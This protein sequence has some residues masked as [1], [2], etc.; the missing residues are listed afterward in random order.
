MMTEDEMIVKAKRA[1]KMGKLRNQKARVDARRHH[2]IRLSKKK[3]KVHVPEPFI[4]AEEL[5]RLYP[6]QFKAMPGSK[7]SKALFVGETADNIVSNYIEERYPDMPVDNKIT[8]WVLYANQ[9]IGVPEGATD[10]PHRRYKK[11][12]WVTTR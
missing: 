6:D 1:Y 12:R 10:V 3:R 2:L 5:V 7:G 8:I 9:V 4:S 11:K